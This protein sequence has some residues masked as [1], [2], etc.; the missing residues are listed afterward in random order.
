[1]PSKIE[2]STPDEPPYAA[3][4]AQA[5]PV[6]LATQSPLTVDPTFYTVRSHDIPDP[7]P[8]PQPH[9]DTL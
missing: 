4:T 8:Q 9:L 6:T 3:Q 7:S 5:G 1:M 2:L